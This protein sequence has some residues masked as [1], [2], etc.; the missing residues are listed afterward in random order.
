MP[1]EQAVWARVRT[2]GEL[3]GETEA[4][5]CT[6]QGVEDRVE[7]ITYDREQ[8]QVSI[9]LRK[10]MGGSTVEVSLLRV[11]HE[12]RDGRV[13][14]ITRLMALAVR[15]QE[16][17]GSGTVKDY[18][19]LARLGKVT[20]ARMTQVMNLLNLAPQIQEEILFLP[21][22]REGREAVRESAL[23][24]LPG[25]WSWNE[26]VELWRKLR[27]G[28]EGQYRRW[29]PRGEKNPGCRKV[30]KGRHLADGGL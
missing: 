6:G 3:A 11:G 4:T 12:K 20:R 29:R 24:R 7:R 1:I 14:R 13:P 19:E 30:K 27:N 22:I 28:G 8:K 21:E 2:I 17:L 16:L 26:Q 10:E 15:C 5:V 9:V 25:V 23:R 18:A